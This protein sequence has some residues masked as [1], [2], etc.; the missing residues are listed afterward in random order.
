MQINILPEPSTHVFVSTTNA[1]FAPNQNFLGLVFPVFISISILVFL[2]MTRISYLGQAQEFQDFSTKHVLTFP[3]SSL[4]Q[5]Q[6]LLNQ[7]VSHI[8]DQASLVPI[9]ILVTFHCWDKTPGP[10]NLKDEVFT[11]TH[12]FKSFRSCLTDLYQEMALWKQ[13]MQRE[14]AH[15]ITTRKQM[16]KEQ[17]REGDVTPVSHIF[18]QAHLLTADDSTYEPRGPMTNWLP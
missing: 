7:S 2:A 12:F 18:F 3:N 4:N 14:A 8:K 9:S 16:E 11:L 6:R 10:C 1:I 15:I 5:V 17:T 13:P